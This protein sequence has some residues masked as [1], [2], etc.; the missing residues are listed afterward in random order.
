MSFVVHAQPSLLRN[1]MPAWISMLL[2]M[3]MQKTCPREYIA[4]YHMHIA[5]YSWQLLSV[6]TGRPCTWLDASILLLWVV[7]VNHHRVTTAGSMSVVATVT[8]F[9][10]VCVCDDV[11]ENEYQR[12][13]WRMNSKWMKLLQLSMCFETSVI[14]LSNW[15]LPKWKWQCWTSYALIV[16]GIYISSPTRNKLCSSFQH[17]AKLSAVLFFWEEKA[18]V[19]ALANISYNIGWWVLF[20]STV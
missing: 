10:C 4:M 14:V 2:C 18:K 15:G 8:F 9:Y 17:C 5:I 1:W 6:V 11:H 20:H 7:T 19:H 16:K 3:C 12:I 13:L